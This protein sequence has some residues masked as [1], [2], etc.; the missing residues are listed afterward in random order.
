VNND[1]VIDEKDLTFIGNPWPKLFGGFTNNFSYKGFDLSVLI[2]FSY[3]NQIYNLTKDEGSSPGN[4]NV[5]RNMFTSVLNYAKVGTDGDGNAYL[6]NPN[7][8]IPRIQG[9]KGVNNNFDRYTNKYV[10]DGSYARLKNVTLTYNL[11]SSIL[12]KTKVIH[13]A[14]IAV[15]GQNLFTVTKY[16]GYDP[17]VGAYVGPSYNGDTLASTL[18]GVDYGRY[19][20]TRVY[21][22]SVAVDF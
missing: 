7:A 19:P 18:V 10:E 14:R 12:G 9:N 2:T 13:G 6:E 5:G 21:S 22:F 15:S 16:T 8:S 1:G 3:G 17:E 4:I 11:P 20:L